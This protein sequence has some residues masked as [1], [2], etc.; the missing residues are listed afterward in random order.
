M[1][2][3]FLK[4]AKFVAN[5]QATAMRLAEANAEHRNYDYARFLSAFNNIN[6]AVSPKCNV[7]V[8]DMLGLKELPVDKQNMSLIQKGFKYLGYPIPK[9]RPMSV[10]EMYDSGMVRVYPRKEDIPA[11]ILKQY[12]DN[13]NELLIRK[14]DVIIN[15]DRSHV[16][17]VTDPTNPKLMNSANPIFGV[18]ERED[19]REL[20]YF[21]PRQDQLISDEQYKQ[22]KR[23]TV[24][25]FGRSDN[26]LTNKLRD[27][28][29]NNKSDNTSEK[30]NSPI[31]NT[32]LAKTIRKAVRG[33]Y[34][35]YYTPQQKNSKSIANSGIAK[36]I[37]NAV[38]GEYDK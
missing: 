23:P 35:T 36:M 34:T 3:P 37:R 7:Y 12:K 28:V 5:R 16:G 1:F 22:L 29:L 25:I 20:E 32:N 9:T 19:N 13:A 4:F 11:D 2:K 33:G 21:R 15:K 38:R 31:A 26:S 14:G 8:S 18:R 27:Q 30:S 6:H 10:K 17:L 24:S